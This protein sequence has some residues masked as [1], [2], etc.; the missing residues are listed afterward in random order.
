M[1]SYVKF[2]TSQSL[3]RRDVTTETENMEA[4]KEYQRFYNFARLQQIHSDLSKLFGGESWGYSTCTRWAREFANGREA[5]E[6]EHRSGAPKPV[7]SENTIESVRQQ[8]DQD[9]HSSILEIS[10]NLGLSYGTFQAIILEDLT[11]KK[12]CARRV[13]SILTE[14]QKRQRVLWCTKIITVIGALWT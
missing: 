1:T 12:V 6:V 5:V 2:V 7:R 8:F 10:S 4:K 13:P 9:S 3:R 14:D 11:L